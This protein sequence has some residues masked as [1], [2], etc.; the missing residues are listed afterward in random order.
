MK[1]KSGNDNKNI[2]IDIDLPHTIHENDINVVKNNKNNNLNNHKL[3]NVN[4]I[5][6]NNGAVFDR[7]AVNL[8]TLENK[9]DNESILGLNKD[10][11]IND[12]VILCS[13]NDFDNDNNLVNKKYVDNKIDNESILRL[14]K[15]NNINDNVILC[16]KN[17]FDNDNN[18]VNKKYVDNLVSNYNIV[19]LNQTFEN[20]L[21]V[22][23]N[24]AD[25]RLQKYI[26]NHLT[27]TTNFL[28]ANSGNDLFGGVW[29]LHVKK[30]SPDNYFKCVNTHTNL[31]SG[32]GPSI[33]PSNESNYMYIETSGNNHDSD[34]SNYCKW[35]TYQFHY[36]TKIS[37]QNNRYSS[38]N[39]KRMGAFTIR[40]LKK[41][42]IVGIQ[43]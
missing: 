2:N 1:N 9:I 14:N 38:G 42:T 3:L 22:N 17:D 10:N 4:S 43:Y 24:G 26:K 18:L 19:R 13:K 11:N 7:D 23:I 25:Y 32:T 15:D 36:I 40:L 21:S 30:Y 6:I 34:E 28:L 39:Q 29:I 37:F 16:S 27:Y 41:K 8:I 20:Y 35:S 33:L 31:T 5:T 12:N